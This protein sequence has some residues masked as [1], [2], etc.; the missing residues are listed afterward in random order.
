MEVLDRAITKYGKP[1]VIRLDNGPEF[2]S[3]VFDAWAYGRRVQLDFI[4]PGKPTENGF[5]E[6]FNGK[7]RDECLSPNWFECLEGARRTIESWAG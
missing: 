4:T 3:R 2:T 6:S 1:L 7:F 5:I